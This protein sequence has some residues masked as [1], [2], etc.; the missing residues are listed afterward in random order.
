MLKQVEREQ[1]RL[2]ASTLARQGVEVRRATV[3][4]DYCFTVYQE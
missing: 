1:H 4:G 3:T 2:M